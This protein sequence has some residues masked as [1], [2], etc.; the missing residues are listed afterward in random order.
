MANQYVQMTYE[1]YKAMETAMREFK[2]TSHTTVTGFYHKSIRIPMGDGTIEFHG[3][4]VM[5][6]E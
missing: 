1:E 2:E 5:A 3:P 6:A 4:I